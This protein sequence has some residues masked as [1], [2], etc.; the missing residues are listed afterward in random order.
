MEANELRDRI[1][2]MYQSGMEAS[3]IGR[4]V[5]RSEQVIRY[6]LKRAGVPAR[7]QRV[8]WPVE[9]MREWY[10][11][12]GLTFQQIADRLNQL[13]QMVGKV[14]RKNGFRTRRT[15]PK[16]GAEHTGWKGGRQLDKHGYVLVYCKGHP[17]A[18]DGRYIR[19]HRLVME[20]HLGRYLERGE[21]VH[22]INGDR[23]DN[24]IENLFLFPS[25]TEHL[26][27][28]LRGQCPRWTE[29]GM[30]RIAEMCQRRFGLEPNA[31][32]EAL[33][34]HAHGSPQT[35]RHSTA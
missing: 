5:K 23:Q 17:H 3:A 19:E 34:Q 21:V 7:Q 29:D 2:A 10:E 4:I 30:A 31:V 15:G 1:V 9:Q 22:H 27:E 32:I 24:R 20:Q 26:R 11:K 6:H 16:S 12:D 18:K 25:N 28:T 13:P 8:D 35:T 14:A 33:R